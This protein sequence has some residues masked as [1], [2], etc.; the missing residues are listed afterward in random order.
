MSPEFLGAVYE[1]SYGV[2]CLRPED[3]GV[4]GALRTYGEYGRYEIETIKGITGADSNVLI[5]GAHL[6]AIVVP[7]SKHVARI[8]AIEAN[9]ATFKLFELNLRLNECHNVGAHC[10]AASDSRTPIEFVLST[11]NSGGS[12]RMPKIRDPRYFEDKPKTTIVPA[13]RL[14]DLFADRA[15]DVILMDIEGSEYFAM[16]GMPRLLGAAKYLIAEFIPHHLTNV[17]GIGVDEFV[18]PLVAFKTM[19][20]PV[21]RKCVHGADIRSLLQEMLDR[22]ITDTSITFCREQIE[23]A[24]QVQG[25]LPA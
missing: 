17:A 4:G 1:T 19:V 13:A 5:V 15:F 2:F 3:I 24:F 6:G 7:L 20:V 16:K 9:P 11:E 22:D 12:K 25:G 21:M 10:L 18:A 8:D 14:D 23:V